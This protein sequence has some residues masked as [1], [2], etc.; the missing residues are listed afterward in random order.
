MKNSC[1]IHLLKFLLNK[2]TS[3]GLPCG[4]VLKNIPANAGDMGLIPGLRRFYTQLIFHS[5]LSP[6]AT[7]TEPVLW[8]PRATILKPMNP[9]ACAPQQEKPSQ[10]EASAPQLQSRLLQ[11]E[12]AHCMKQWRPSSAKNKQTSKWWY[13]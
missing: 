10:W 2:M 9:R 3:S 1:I 7:T 13:L 11:L 12:K 6:R 4:S 8:S 5:Q